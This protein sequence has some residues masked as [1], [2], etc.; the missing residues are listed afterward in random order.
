MKQIILIILL[1]QCDSIVAQNC[2]EGRK[3][4][5]D[6]QFRIAVNELKSCLKQS[7]EDSSLYLLT[8]ISYVKLRDYRKGKAYLQEAINRNVRNMAAANFYFGLCLLQEG[9]NN[10]GLSFM[11]N[12]AQLGFSRFTVMDTDEFVWV[13]DGKRFQDIRMKV[14]ENAFPCLKD[15]NNNKFDFWLGEWDVY[16]SNKKSAHSK[17]T[18]AVGGCAV[19]ED[20]VT[21]SGLYAGQSISYYDPETELWN[22]YWVGSAA[23]KSKYYETEG[24]EANMQFITKGKNAQGIDSWTKM[25]YVQENEDTVIQILESSTDLGATWS[26]AFHGTYKRKKRE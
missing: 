5:N 20:Y 12:A 11:E 23:D 8:G 25:S 9:N 15:P 22:Q 16:T 1:I 3:S 19:H 6:K 26:V 17:I 10:E 14:K 21:L 4:F 24:Y 18:K 7:P 2:L 13:R